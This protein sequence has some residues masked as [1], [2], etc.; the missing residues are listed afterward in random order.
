[1]VYIFSIFKYLKNNNKPIIISTNWELSQGFVIYKNIFRF[2]LVTILHG[3]EVTRLNSS[4][5]KKNI[6][7]FKKTII[8]SDKIIS[9][10][11]TL[12]KLLNL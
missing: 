3:L 2:S 4:K 12:K 11:N 9:V 6:K 8:R 5:Y 7:S 10:S 1:M